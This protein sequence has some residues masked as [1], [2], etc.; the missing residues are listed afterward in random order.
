MWVRNDM[1]DG[2]TPALFAYDEE[3][4]RPDPILVAGRV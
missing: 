4:E 3:V 1:P 2:P